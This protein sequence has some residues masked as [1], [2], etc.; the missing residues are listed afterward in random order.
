MFLD[1][2]NATLTFG[3]LV[4]VS[5]ATFHVEENEIVSII[6]PNGAGKTTIFNILTGLYKVDHGTGIF[7]GENIFDNK[8]PQD[9]AKL[10][11]SRTFQNIRLF[12][13]MRVIENVL[14]GTHIHCNYRLWDAIFR[15]KKYREE[16][17]KHH[18]NAVNILESIGLHD[19][20]HT[21]AKNLPYGD[22]RKLE[23]ARGMAT[24]PKLLLLDEP[25]AGMNPQESHELMEFIRYL[26]DIG[27][28]ILLIEHDMKV[29]MNISD[30]IY[31]FDHGKKIAEGVPEEIANNPEVIRAY[32]GEEQN[33]AEDN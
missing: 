7:C 15:T 4:A 2:Q 27:Y 11:I 5:D 9:I 32:L 6:G 25:A 22:Q 21:L 14:T 24:S 8:T 19:R 26:R 16:E 18:Q 33:D 17:R 10:G 28:T 1:V 29:V 30:R 13:S 31:V 3:G 23:I 12:S 20:I